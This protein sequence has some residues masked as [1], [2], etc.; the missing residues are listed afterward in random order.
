MSL[1]KRIP[2]LLLRLIALGASVC[3]IVIMV[4]S[5]DSAQV[6]GMN[7]SA[8]YSNIP[9][10]KY[11]V[12]V[13]AI[14]SAYT[15]ILLCIPSK[16]SCGHMILVLDLVIAL[17]LDSSISACVAIGL[18]GK[19]GNT[20]AGWLPICGQVPKF[21]DHVTG[22][23]AAGFIAAIAYFLVVLYSVHSVMNL[24]APRA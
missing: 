4:T 22:A 6:F 5:R 17:L 9:T 13:N 16:N 11:F 21:C 15:L 14:A 19:K 12:L 23:I 7:I 20:H 8:K 3:A 18:V 10:F 1:S 24:F 2:M